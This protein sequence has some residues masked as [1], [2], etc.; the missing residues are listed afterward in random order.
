M[1][2]LPMLWTGV[3]EHH[4]SFGGT[5]TLDGHA[6]ARRER[7]EAKVFG[8]GAVIRGMETINIGERNSRFVLNYLRTERIT[9]VSKDV[10]DGATVAGNPARV[11]EPRD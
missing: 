1:L 9:V 2:V 6:R 5:I 7:L 3:S 10:P 4:M 8:G 11:I